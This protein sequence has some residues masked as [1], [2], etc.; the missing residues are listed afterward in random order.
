MVGHLEACTS[1]SNAAILFGVNER[2]VYEILKKSKDDESLKDRRRS[3]RP[4]VTDNKTDD[5][6]VIA[7]LGVV[8]STCSN[9]ICYQLLYSCQRTRF[10]WCESVPTDHEAKTH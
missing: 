5:D 3:G 9:W 10:Y 8:R 7:Y 2:T 1:T 4:R 6:V